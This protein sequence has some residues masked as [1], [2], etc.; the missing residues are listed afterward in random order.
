[1]TISS[2]FVLFRIFVNL[3][4]MRNDYIAIIGLEIHAQLK[5]KSKMFAPDPVTYGEEPNVFISPT[6][7]ALPGALPTVNKNGVKMAVKMGLATHCT[8]HKKTLFA[9]KNYFYP[10]L[11]KGYQISQYDTPVCTGGFVNIKLPDG[12]KKKIRIHRIHIE[13]DTGKSL[14]EYDIY[15]SLLDF[16]R[17]GT[18]LIEIVSEADIR[19]PEEAM[20]YVREIRRLVRYL[21]ICDGNME[22]GSLRC[23]V[24][25]S[26]MK[27]TDSRW[28]TKVEV[29]NMNSISAIGKALEYEI[30]RQIEEL[31]S[32]GKIY[33]ETRMW[34][35]TQEKTILMR[36][37]E[38]ADDYRYFPEPDLPYL[39]VSDELIEEIQAEMPA[40]PEELEN[41]YLNEYKLPY[42]DVVIIVEQRQFAEYFQKVAENVGNYKAAANWVLGPV[43]A[44]LNTMATDIT[45]FPI[46]PEDLA[47]LIR[48]PLEGKVNISV[49]KDKLFRLLLENPQKDPLK[50]AEENNLLLQ[51]D[52]EEIS[53]I[54]EDLLAKNPDKVQLYRNGKTGLLGFFVGQVMRATKGKAN[55]KLVNQK[56]KQLLEQ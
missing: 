36:R 55:P 25:V 5:T 3:R 14:H 13:E 32:G 4:L 12:S 7:L 11:P 50:I 52:D 27:K 44:Y 19:T 29:K 51:H 15:D 49:A 6:T 21:D 42:E 53:S 56:L 37:K 34:N 10:D 22:E 48:L 39:F 46:S 1:M 33:Q 8:I 30:R 47:K 41:K 9:R 26:V 45:K 2:A 17:A 38:T 54:I 23:D 16:N 20:A 40:L 43:R 24:N 35:P 31:E 18:P 28:G